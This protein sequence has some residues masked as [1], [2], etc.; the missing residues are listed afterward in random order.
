MMLSRRNLLGAVAAASSLPAR[1]WAQKLR[2]SIAEESDATLRSAAAQRGIIYGAAV[3]TTEL[4]EQDFAA[5]LTHE[6]A[7]LAPEY[8]MK[9]AIVEQ[10]PGQYD[11]SG[12]DAILAFTRAHGL[13]FRGVPLVWHKRNPEWLEA[14]A[15]KSRDET[16]ITGFIERVAGHF[17]GR[18]HSWDVV[19]EAIAPEDGRA[20][21]LRNSFWLQVYGPHYIDLAYHAARAADPGAM[22]VYNDWGCE[23]GAPANDR[24]RAATL[25]FLEQAMARGVPIDALGLQG[26]MR[27]FGTPIDQPKLAGFLGRVKSMGL[28]ILVTEHDVDDSGGPSDLA[29]RDRAVADASRRFLDVMIDAGAIAVLTWG[30]SDRFLDSPGW[31]SKLT[32]YQP[33]MLPLD[34]HLNRTPM[35]QEMVTAFAGR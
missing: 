2:S 9:R 20:D 10:I 18:V 33:R 25:D 35:W 22:L 28:R 29:L 13:M 23:L 5:V 8:E 3:N 34:S 31:S 32:G 17:R 14:A 11:F 6:A 24:F 21:S 1:G 27:A 16:L 15:R 19:N 30:L 26:H 7:I 12:C 4:G